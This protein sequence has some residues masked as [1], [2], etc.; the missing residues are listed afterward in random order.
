MSEAILSAKVHE[1]ATEYLARK[2]GKSRPAGTYD[3]AGRWYPATGEAKDCCTHVRL[4]SRAYPYSL[5]VHCY[6]LK[7]V[8]HLYDV[9]AKDVRRCVKQLE[10]KS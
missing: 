2:H 10:V 4:P 3:Q 9:D 5:L 1:A 7:H 6:T 8:V